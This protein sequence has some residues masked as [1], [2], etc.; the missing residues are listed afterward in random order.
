[1]FSIS[2]RRLIQLCQRVAT[3]TRAGIE[4]RKL[5]T[6]EASH[7]SA[8]H[9]RHMEQVSRQVLSGGTVAEGLRQ[10]E[11]YFPSLLVQMVAIG[12]QTGKLDEVLFRLAEYYEH[13]LAMRRMLLLGIAWPVFQLSL[14][15]VIIGI[16]IWAF[17]FAAELSGGEPFDVLGIG[18]VG[19]SG[20]VIYF[21][22]V[23]ALLSTA[24]VGL[25]A[26]SRGAL[27]PKPILWAMQ[28][29]LI[30]RCLESFALA[31]LTWTLGTALDSGMDARRSAELAIDAA[32]NQYYASHREAVGRT[33]AQGEEFHEAFRR[34][35]AFPEDFLQ[36]LE[37]AEMA[38]ATTE[39]LLRLTREY[40]E[41]ARNA[42]RLL[43]V[44][45]TAAVFVLV[46]CI[47]IVLIFRLFGL[48]MGTIHEALDAID[49]P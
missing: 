33:I 13:R 45:T 3:G 11:G 8:T 1:M 38:G 29:P 39:A 49:N 9:R 18:L 32:Q 14:A 21:T 23:A 19:T 28:L 16:L 26:V 15:V 46:G 27:G 4:A 42:M 43:T 31:R 40:E 30:G 44:V 48:Y 2:T 41:R 47:L 25:L 35:Y 34:T 17:G 24:T 36:S 20:M 22:I 37:M 10:G 12:E 7:G 6:S 5:W